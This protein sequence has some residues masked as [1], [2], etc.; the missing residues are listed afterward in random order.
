MLSEKKKSYRYLTHRRFKIKLFSWFSF[1]SQDFNANFGLSKGNMSLKLNMIRVLHRGTEH[2]E[3]LQSSPLHV[4][5]AKS[6]DDISIHFAYTLYHIQEIILTQWKHWSGNPGG[7]QVCWSW[8]YIAEISFCQSNI[9]ARKSLN[10][11]LKEVRLRGS[12]VS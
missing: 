11:W 7:G 3:I 6:R 10:R 5:Y 12:S 1:F 9:T 4:S 2:L 8:E